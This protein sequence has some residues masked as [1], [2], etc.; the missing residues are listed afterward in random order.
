M[1]THPG[2]QHGPPGP[3]HHAGMGPALSSLPPGLIDPRVTN[4]K[5]TIPDTS[6]QTHGNLCQKCCFFSFC[7]GLAF[8]PVSVYLSAC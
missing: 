1:Q 6:T 5:T 3:H 2:M 4:T 7:F 8:L